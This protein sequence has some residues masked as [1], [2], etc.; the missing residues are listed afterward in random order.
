LTPDVHL[1]LLL[2]QTQTPFLK[3]QPIYL[4]SFAIFY[5]LPALPGCA[6]EAMDS[7]EEEWKSYM[8]STMVVTAEL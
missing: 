2:W 8:D 4:I 1:G 6:L 5:P 3:G 7:S